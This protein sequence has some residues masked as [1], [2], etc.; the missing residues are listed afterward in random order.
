MKD[1]VK[2]LEKVD[3]PELKAL[4]VD[5]GKSIARRP[6]RPFEGAR[7]VGRASSVAAHAAP[8]DPED[9]K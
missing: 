7:Y 6:A 4:L 2:L 1:P 3:D 9:E 8:R 5:L